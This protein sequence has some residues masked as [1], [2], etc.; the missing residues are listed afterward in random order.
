LKIEFIY[1]ATGREEIDAIKLWNS[2]QT[3]IKAAIEEA[4]LT[5]AQISFLAISSHRG[6][7]TCWNR[8]SG[9]VYHNFITAQDLRADQMVRDCNDGFMFKAFK[10]SAS[11]LHCVTRSQRYLGQSVFN[12]TNADVTMR[13]AW[14]LEQCPGI[15]Q[16]LKQGDVLFGT[17]DAWLLY[18]LRRGVSSDKDIDHI[19]DITNC[20]ASGLY[21]PFTQEWT[22]WAPMLYPIKRSILPTVVDNSFDF[23]YVDKS[24]FG[25]SIK[26]GTSISDISA[27]LWGNCCFDKTDLFIRMDTTTVVNIITKS[28]CLASE[29]E[30]FTR[31]GYKRLSA[32][33][34][35]VVYVLEKICNDCTS[36]IDWGMKIDLFTDHHDASKQACSVSDSNG[37]FFV[38]EFNVMGRCDIT[39][40]SS[41]IGIKKATRK[42]HLVR[43]LL[44][45]LVYRFALLY[46]S[47]HKEIQYQSLEC[48]TKIKVDGSVA[49]NDFVCQ[50]LADITSLPVERGVAADASA[51]G[52]VL[53]AGFNSHIWNSKQE[54]LQVRKIDKIFL[55][56]PNSKLKLLR[57]MRCWE[58]LVEKFKG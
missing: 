39:A 41:F 49:K 11:M 33:Q 53:L 54:L 13:L 6:S 28:T 50:M 7:F 51:L 45:S 56:S 40:G 1:P 55:P 34:D 12:V 37:V 16:D 17:I 10:M 20:A 30:M 44:E 25:S 52:A 29:R 36:V 22:E 24:L 35:E 14:V 9:M 58:E 4:N 42:E 21:D 47:A 5:A 46:V 43:A 26:I 23:G 57:N 3:T 19:S 31:I 48:F 18:R 27:A 38:S 2:V 15:Q 32:T 8:C